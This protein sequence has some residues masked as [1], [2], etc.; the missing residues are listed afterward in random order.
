MHYRG[1]TWD[2]PHSNSALMAAA[3]KLD[4]ATDAISISWDKHSLEGFE[5]HPIGDLCE[6]YDLVVLDHPHVGEAVAAGCLQ[7]LESLLAAS[8]IAALERDTIGPSLSSYQL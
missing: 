7:P 6:R 8:E 3:A 1:L 5:A 4:A 2:H